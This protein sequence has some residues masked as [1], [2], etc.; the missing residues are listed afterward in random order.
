MKS[1]Y[2]F[3]I[4]I[5]VNTLGSGLLGTLGAIANN[6][7]LSFIIL[8]CFNLASLCLTIYFQIL[9]RES[10]TPVV[11]AGALSKTKLRRKNEKKKNS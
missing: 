3:V 2:I 11:G 6:Y 1:N 5:I 10:S 7:L 4:S 9:S 8:F